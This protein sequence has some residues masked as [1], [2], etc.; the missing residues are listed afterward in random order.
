MQIQLLR[1]PGE[2]I[3]LDDDSA[4]ALLN[5]G[6]ATVVRDTPTKET[7]ILQPVKETADRP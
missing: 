6:L 4:V 1:K 3:T 2:A 7:A 5:A